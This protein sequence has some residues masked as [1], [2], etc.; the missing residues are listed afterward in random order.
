MIFTLLTSIVMGSEGG[1]NPL[2]E[3]ALCRRLPRKARSV[4]RLPLAKSKRRWASRTTWTAFRTSAI[5]SGNGQGRGMS[6]TGGGS[7]AIAGFV[8]QFLNTIDSGLTATLGHGASGAIL[9]LEP[10]YADATSLAGEAR[11]VQYKTR[12]RRPWS[13]HDILFNV[14][15]TLLRAALVCAD[16]DA[17]PIFVTSGILQNGA[18]LRAFLAQPLGNGETDQLRVGHVDRS[19]ASLVTEITN[20]VGSIKPS[21][22]HLTEERVVALLARVQIDEAVRQEDVR[23]RIFQLL[24]RAT[25]NERLAEAAFNALFR[26]IGEV[27]QDAGATVHADAF[28]EAAGLTP[29]VLGPILEFDRRVTEQLRRTLDRRGY[30]EHRDVRAPLDLP[31]ASMVLVEAP[32]GSGKT[33]TLAGLALRAARDGAIAVWL[34]RPATIEACRDQIIDQLWR[35]TLQRSDET[36]FH[37]LAS[38]VANVLG[39]DQAPAI[40]VLIDQ[41]PRHP[42]ARADLLQFDWA[43][44]GMRLIVACSTEESAAARVMPAALPVRLGDF[45]QTQLRALLLSYDLSW[46]S[47]PSEARRWISRPVLAGLYTSLATASAGWVANSEYDLFDAFAERARTRGNTEGL[48][49]CRQ[50]IGAFGGQALNGVPLCVTALG[51]DW[52]P[53]HVDLLVR[54]G[55]LSYDADDALIFAHDRLRDWAVA[56]HLSRCEMPPAELSRTLAHVAGYRLG[57]ELLPPSANYALMDTLWLLARTATGAVKIAQLLAVW[58]DDPDLWQLHDDLYCRLLPTGGSK[59]LDALVPALLTRLASADPGRSH[60]VVACAKG[61]AEAGQAS[62]EA[63]TRF[64]EASESDAKRCGCLMLAALPDPS[65]LELI[66]AIHRGVDQ[67]PPQAREHALSTAAWSAIRAGALVTPE[68]ASGYFDREISRDPGPAHLLSLL[69]HLPDGH[70]IW[71]KH[72]AALVERYGSDLHARYWLASCVGAFDDRR[73]D[74]ALSAWCID[75][76]SMAALPAWTAVCR[77]RPDLVVALA[78][79]M[80]PGIFS[81]DTERWIA[82][83]LQPGREAA[84]AAVVAAIKASDESGCN[85]A[86]ILDTRSDAL[87]DTE[88]EWAGLR[89]AEALIPDQ[90]EDLVAARL[91]GF[92]AEIEDPSR[93]AHL[94]TLMPLGLAARLHTVAERRIA[95]VGLSND[96]EFEAA[97]T[98]LRYL[99]PETASALMRLKLSQQNANLRRNAVRETGLVDLPSIRA[100]IETIA[101]ADEV[102]DEPGRLE[103]VKLIAERDPEW[104]R[105]RIESLLASNHPSAINEAFWLAQRMP[106]DAFIAEAI[107]RLPALFSE[108]QPLWRVVDYLV[109]RRAGAAAVRTELIPALTSRASDERWVIGRLLGLNDP[110][111]DASVLARLNTHTNRYFKA[112][113]AFWGAVARPESS[114]WQAM[115]RDA[116]ATDAPLALRH[117]PGFYRY[118]ARQTGAAHDQLLSDAYPDSEFEHGRALS[119]IHA[120]S[121]VDRTLAADA[122]GSLCRLFEPDSSELPKFCDRLASGTFDGGRAVIFANARTWPAKCLLVALTPERSPYESDLIAAVEGGLTD[123]EPHVRRIA[124]ICAPLIL[125]RA[126]PPSLLEDSSPDV[127][128]AAEDAG[129]RLILRLRAIDL[130]TTIRS[131]TGAEARQAASILYAMVKRSKIS[132]FPPPFS[133]AEFLHAAQP[134]SGLAALLR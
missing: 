109:S 52:L 12:G 34:D 118:A 85:F 112:E 123:A 83:L 120:I 13:N 124:C 59:L 26:F 61:F 97:E 103:A 60:D 87:A 40:L 4:F 95:N 56:E 36:Q 17:R 115:A 41:L 23:K 108:C 106:G 11:I 64:L 2:F 49:G 93:I 38:D 128:S 25:G 122:L 104:G 19:Y 105:L 113:I 63:I 42:D 88:V 18:V 37:R 50:L 77:W 20:R 75:P 74:E 28:L 94:K 39:R 29:S 21:F 44:A 27:S 78:A 134:G 62:S 101:N 111:A 66:A 1:A 67:A 89:L 58:D 24:L 81:V 7:F 119:A 22:E 130:L 121:A 127:R 5:L 70:A 84:L 54:T 110:E 68:W 48:H 98:I 80:P 100:E 90:R 43:A 116:I 35:Q 82:P 86:F 126:P 102:A 131:G 30:D 47:I 96:P 32:S 99:G 14:L 114:G 125:G 15:P 51:G 76:H 107:E 71:A 57:D 73:F 132:R 53:G 79:L 6:G 10:A 92:F 16:D 69:P 46:A 55:W 129:R 72:G 8:Y 31:D 3:P 65:R 117:L 33:W 133:R 9:R 91:L 45:S